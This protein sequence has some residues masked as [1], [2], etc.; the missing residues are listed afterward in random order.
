VIGQ[1]FLY[2]TFDMTGAEVGITAL[3]TM[4]VTLG[5]LALW[6]ATQRTRHEHEVEQA[7]NAQIS[8]HLHQFLDLSDRSRALAERTET[9]QQSADKVQLSVKRD[10]EQI[11]ADR[12][13]LT[14]LQEELTE[15]R[16]RWGQLVPT[17]E[18]IDDSPELLRM[19]ADQKLGAARAASNPSESEGAKREAN[20]YLRRLL[21]HPDADSLDLE[22]GGDLAREQLRMPTLARQ[23]YERA[24]EVDPSNVSAQAELAALRIRRPSEREEALQELIDLATEH[25]EVKNA[26][27]S[28]FN[29]FIDIDRY[30]DLAATCKRLLA[31]DP[32]DTTAW[33]NLGVALAQLDNNHSE[34]RDAYEKA[35]KFSR[36]KGE[37]GDL[38]NAARAF[39]RFLRD[40]GTDENLVYARELLEE[41]VRDDPLESRVLSALADTLRMQG[42]A[43]QA[44]H[45]YE[46]AERLGS[47]IEAPY[48]RRRREEI[49][50]LD[51]LGLLTEDPPQIDGR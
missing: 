47:P 46:V 8:A 4:V 41:A 11:S 49:A 17:M 40:E 35:I 30:D 37:P 20:A 25:P 14:A 9:I 38:G 5:T 1:T 3:G 44:N 27:F 42:D 15:L 36:E 50:V 34:A 18:A 43:T 24:I 48:A 6:R 33:R 28:L 31:S 32:S 13:E 45:Y 23:L 21:Q 51:E 10:Q 7:I 12:M 26:R 39:S 22:I 29:H 19:T 2:C 16:D